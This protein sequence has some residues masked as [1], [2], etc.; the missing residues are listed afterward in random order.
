M[1]RYIITFESSQVQM[2]DQLKSHKDRTAYLEKV[3][4]DLGGKLIEAPITR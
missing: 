1:K 4:Q 3:H 2:Q